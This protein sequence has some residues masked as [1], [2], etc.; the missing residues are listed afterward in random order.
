MKFKKIKV[1]K[2]TCFYE[3]AQ[4]IQVISR[5]MLKIQC[6]NFVFNLCIVLFLINELY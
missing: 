5:N 4:N 2:Q 1:D 6:L 3:H